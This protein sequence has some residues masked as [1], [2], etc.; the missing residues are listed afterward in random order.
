MTLISIRRPQNETISRVEIARALESLASHKRSQGNPTDADALQNMASFLH[1]SE[2]GHYSL[3]EAERAN[4]TLGT[5]HAISMDV[6]P[7]IKNVGNT[8]YLNSLLQYL[9]TL[10]PI[11]QL[12]DNFEEHKLE[13]DEEHVSQRRCGS[14]TAVLKFEHAMVAR[15]C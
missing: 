2:A 4:S 15:I 11:R 13:L 5:T 12:L 1:D 6:P 14:T 3:P 8:C 9:Y 7:G 10:V